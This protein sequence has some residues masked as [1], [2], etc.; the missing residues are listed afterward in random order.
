MKGWLSMR[1]TTD[2]CGCKIL[3][4]KLGMLQCTHSF[5][6]SHN[7]SA[8]LPVLA[9]S[10]MSMHYTVPNHCN[11]RSLRNWKINSGAG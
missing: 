3:L 4:R 6:V 9:G 1:E 11:I 2:I 8:A 10:I 7:F 5:P